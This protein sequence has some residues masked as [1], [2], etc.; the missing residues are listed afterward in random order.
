MPVGGVG[1]YYAWSDLTKSIY[2][3]GLDGFN[4]PIMWR[5]FLDIERWE[6][7]SITLPTVLE[8]VPSSGCMVIVNDILLLFGGLNESN[9]T[10]NQIYIYNIPTSTWR[11]GAPSM[12]TR[13]KMACATAGDY[14]VVWGGYSNGTEPVNTLFYNFKKDIWITNSGNN[15]TDLPNVG[16]E[17]SKSS[18]SA[19]IGGS[20]A[21]IV[22]VGAIIGFIF[23]RHRRRLLSAHK[24]HERK[25]KKI[26]SVSLQN[27]VEGNALSAQNNSNVSKNYHIPKANATLDK[28]SEAVTGSYYNNH[29]NKSTDPM[30]ANRESQ[31]QLPV[32]IYPSPSITEATAA[33][34]DS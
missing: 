1:M 12:L 5:F 20:I 3:I 26:D 10:T 22:V 29:D 7:L 27:E 8:T 21:A 30:S 24:N 28:P 4:K 14:F 11:R 6:T 17:T 19:I 13:A 9:T 25:H 34:S 32:P 33:G 23:F 15:S 16:A 31:Y 18:K 2:M